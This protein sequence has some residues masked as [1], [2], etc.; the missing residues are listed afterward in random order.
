MARRQG[1]IKTLRNR[2]YRFVAPVEE[3]VDTLQEE[4]AP[5]ALLPSLPSEGYPWD[6]AGA[7]H[8][9]TLPPRQ[10]AESLLG[11]PLPP[12]HTT[13]QEGYI[14]CPQCQQENSVSASFCGECGARLVSVCPVCGRVESLHTRFC[15]ACGTL[16]ST[17]VVLQWLRCQC[18]NCC[19]ATRVVIVFG[20][21]LMPAPP[22]RPGQDVVRRLLHGQHHAPEEPANLLDAQWD[23]RPRSAL[24]AARLLPREGVGRLFFNASTAIAPA[25]RTARSA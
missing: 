1:C 13:P 20:A 6:R 25:R 19:A 21:G 18:I 3:R 12:P 23:A 7:T 8:T 17:T 22:V 15:S 9:P 11:G 24:K 4:E 10:Q 2:G 5:V 16:L 14:A